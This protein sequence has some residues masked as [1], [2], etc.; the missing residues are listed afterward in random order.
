MKT[1]LTSDDRK[2]FVLNF[3]AVV[4]GIAITFAVDNMISSGSERRE[5][6]SSLNLVKNELLDDIRYA[7]EADSMLL[8]YSRSAEF[9]V[10]YEGKYDRAPSDSLQMY[11]IIPLTIM[12]VTYSDDAL[13]LLKTSSLFTKIGDLDLS[14]DIIHTYG[15][16]QDQFK[17]FHMLFDLCN[18]NR[19]AA[20]TENVKKVLGSNDATFP[21]LWTAITSTTEGRQ[22]IHGLIGIHTMSTSRKMRE[23]VE[24]TVGKIEQYVGN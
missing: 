22:F 19:E 15:S 6:K 5:V 8:S 11:A 23:T 3:L 18:K 21:S 12:E 16:I 10:R 14:L 20:F 7:D 24:K 9:L 4:L 17:Q 2:S 1:R 13:D